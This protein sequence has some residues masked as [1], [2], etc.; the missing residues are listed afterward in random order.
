MNNDKEFNELMKTKKMTTEEAIKTLKE[1]RQL[2]TGML[3]PL[4]ISYESFL[5]FSQLPD[6]KADE[7]ISGLIVL[8]EKKIIDIN[9]KG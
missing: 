2:S 8:V 5:R 7:I 4:G 3:E 6:K 1:T 9:Q